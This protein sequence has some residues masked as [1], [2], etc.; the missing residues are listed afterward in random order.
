MKIK[1]YIK[2]VGL[3]LTLGITVP[4]L[5][6]PLTSCDDDETPITELPQS[7]ATPLPDSLEVGD[8]LIIETNQGQLIF[9]LTSE[10][11][12]IFDP[13]FPDRD[14]EFLNFFYSEDGENKILSMRPEITGRFATTLLNEEITAANTDLNSFINNYTYPPTIDQLSQVITSEETE[15]VLLD[16][17][18]EDLE[19][20]IVDRITW[21][22]P[23][24]GEGAVLI[25]NSG[26]RTGPDGTSNGIQLFTDI[27]RTT[28]NIQIVKNV[29]FVPAN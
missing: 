17:N 23:S 12:I 15:Y 9:S 22:L 3:K 11:G 24:D 18:E 16:F 21:T 20:F 29:I 8:Q 5:S 6:I 28:T 7:V 19:L 13:R 4:F 10:G 25:V 27:S 14:P 2:T 1:H 26:N